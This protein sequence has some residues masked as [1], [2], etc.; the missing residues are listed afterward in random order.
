LFV[1]FVDVGSE[2]S[3]NT[4]EAIFPIREYGKIIRESI[5]HPNSKSSY[6]RNGIGDVP[7]DKVEVT[8]SRESDMREALYIW[9]RANCS[10]PSFFINEQNELAFRE[11]EN[12]F[13]PENVKRFFPDISEKPLI[14]SKAVSQNRLTIFD[15]IDLE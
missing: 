13:R 5:R 3:Y 12:I 10:D 11:V 6:G 1:F 4:V 2:D 14:K 9:Y 15:I 8:D 7:I